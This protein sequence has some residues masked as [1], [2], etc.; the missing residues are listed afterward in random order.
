MPF[1]EDLALG[2]LA[3]IHQLVGVLRPVELPDLAENADLPEQ[4]LHAER[5]AFVGHDR[6]DARADRLVAQQRRQDAHERHGRGNFAPLGGR[7][8][9]R[10]ESRQLGDRQ[11]RADAPA[12]RKIAA[13]RFAAFAQVFHFRAVFGKAQKRNLADLVVRD[14]HMKPVAECA[15]RLIAELLLLVGDHLAFAGLAHAVALDG[16]GEDDGRLALVLDGR[17]VGGVDLDRIVAAARQ[18]PD[19]IVGPVGDHRRGLGIAAEEF[20]AD[21]GAVLRLEIL[22]FA[23]DAF[24]HQLA[25]LAGAV[26]RQQLIP[27]RAPQ[28][29]DDVP[30][31]AAKIRLELLDDLAVAAHRPI[32]PLQVA[33]DDEDQIVELLAT[34][35]RDRARA[36]PAR[37]SRRRRKTPTPCAGGVGDLAMVEISQETRLIDRHQRPET[38][39]HRREL[40]EVRHQPG[41][42]IGRKSLALHLLAEVE[43]LL[44]A[45][46]PFEKGA[47]INAGRDMALKIDEVAAMRFGWRRAR[48]A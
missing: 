8:Q 45:E 11:R 32:E 26:A 27:A 12:R 21:V 19:L 10:V 40:P 37:P 35:Q 41:M 25:Q 5:A 17:L 28:A 1:L 24:F 48:N 9:Q 6:H 20:L 15:Q 4:A 43:Q 38:H 34:G 7:L 22:I 16:L 33:V 44:L 42:R 39:R 23:V 36:I 30:A 14:R 31:G 2:I 3:V 46:A 29:F 47:R 18:R 13:E